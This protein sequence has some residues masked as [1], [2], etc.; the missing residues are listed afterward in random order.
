MTACLAGDEVAELV[1]RLGQ[2]AAREIAG[3]LI[4]P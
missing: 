3:K 4:P 1:E 2:V